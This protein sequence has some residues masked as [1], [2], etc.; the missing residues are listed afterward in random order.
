MQLRE[1][2][3]RIDNLE[4]RLA[5][6]NKAKSQAEQDHKRL[7]DQLAKFSIPIPTSNGDIT[8]QNYTFF[9]RLRRQCGFPHASAAQ[10]EDMHK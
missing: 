7:A 5:A 4:L 9:G 6:A 3:R 1:D 8:R 10:A 2:N